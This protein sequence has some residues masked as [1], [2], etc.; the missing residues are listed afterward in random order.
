MG[1]LFSFL[2]RISSWMPWGGR[3]ERLK[4]RISALERRREE[5]VRKSYNKSIAQKVVEI[6]NEIK[7]LREKLANAAKD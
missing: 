7:L 6:E 5:L 1:G 3:I 2:D 4:N